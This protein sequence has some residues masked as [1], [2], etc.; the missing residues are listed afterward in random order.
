MKN[1]WTIILVA[2]VAVAGA[3]VWWFLLRGPGD[4][5]G[6]TEG[7]PDPEAKLRTVRT[8]EHDWPCWGGPRHDNRSDVK[9]IRTKWSGGLKRLW[10][11]DFLCQG[12]KASATWAGPVI[13]GDH[14]VVPGRDKDNDLLFCL[15]PETGKLIWKQSY[16]AETSSAEG[17]GTRATPFID[18]DRVYTFSRGGDLACWQLYDGKPIWRENVH[19]EG[20]DEP[21]WGLA[22]APLVHGGKVIVQGGGSATAIAYDKMTG[23]VAWKW[24]GPGDGDAGYAAVRPMQVGE[25]TQLLVFHATGLAGLKPNDGSR[26]WNIGWPTD[27]GVNAAT[28]VVVGDTV[29]ITSNYKE[30]CAAVKVTPDD[31]RILWKNKKIKSHH[32]D[33]AVI[34]GY[35]YG[36]S[37][38]SNQNRGDLVCLRL[39]DGAEQW[40][41][42]EVGHGTLVEVDGYLL[43]L[44]GKGNLF[45]VKPDPKEFRIVAKMPGA[46]PDVDR[47]AWTR[48]VI[49]NGRLYLRYMQTLICYDLIN[50]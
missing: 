45:L 6:D 29:F 12:D 25:D 44:D 49:A 46:L 19:D 20:G 15:D 32:S 34:D 31:G 27:Y 21:R 14:L 36:Y 35:V 5:S 8:G 10:R 50:K 17:Q 9:H 24:K 39:S 48:P 1:K 18:G 33:A 28:P 11:R 38:T 30:G 2:A 43:C 23:K 42:R 26:I 37:G 13:Q 3:A 40:R 16:A 22:S 41:T 47:N 4:L 7:V